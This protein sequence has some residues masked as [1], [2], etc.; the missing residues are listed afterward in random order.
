MN[1]LFIAEEQVMTKGFERQLKR[2]IKN[3][4]NKLVCPKSIKK[5]FILNF[6]SDVYEYAE[7]SNTNDISQ[8][9]T[10]FGTSDEVVNSMISSLSDD[11]IIRARKKER[12]VMLAT[13]LS[14]IAAFAITIAFI[15]EVLK[16]TGG[17]EVTGFFENKFF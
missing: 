17:Y 15:F 2:Y 9:I 4:E 6:S 5:D 13:V 14:I 10:H 12:I 8:I 1:K 11:E 3:I 7:I 16:F